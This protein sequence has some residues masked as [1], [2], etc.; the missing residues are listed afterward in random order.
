MF[1]SVYCIFIGIQFYTKYIDKVLITSITLHITLYHYVCMYIV[2][3]YMSPCLLS[4]ASIPHCIIYFQQNIPSLQLIN[5]VRSE[6]LTQGAV[7]LVVISLSLSLSRSFLLKCLL[8]SSGV[9]KGEER[10]DCLCLLQPHPPPLS[11]PD[12]MPADTMSLKILSL[13]T[14]FLR[15]LHTTSSWRMLVRSRWLQTNLKMSG[16]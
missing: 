13:T 1:S 11:W 16:W 2:Y 9:G 14:T 5:Y 12:L 4:Q 8:S 7:V 6:P 10:R 3:M 15:S